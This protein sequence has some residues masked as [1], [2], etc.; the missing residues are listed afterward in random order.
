MAG[1]VIAQ[2]A[3]G[4]VSSFDGITDSYDEDNLRVATPKCVKDLSICVKAGYQSKE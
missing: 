1:Q 4:V 2:K 3:G